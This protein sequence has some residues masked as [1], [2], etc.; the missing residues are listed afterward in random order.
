MIN[1]Y[2]RWDKYDRLFIDKEDG[3]AFVELGW[4]GAP[5]AG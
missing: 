2:D 4:V 3:G 1:R 5:L